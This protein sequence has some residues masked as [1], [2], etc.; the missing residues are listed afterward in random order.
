MTDVSMHLTAQ[1]EQIH[2]TFLQKIQIWIFAL[3][4][5]FFTASLVPLLLG[6]TIAYYETS[7]IDLI[8]GLLTLVAGVS[9]HAGTNLINDYYDRSTD[10]INIYYSQ[11]NGGSR[12]IQNDIIAPRKI[13]QASVLSYIVGSVTAIIIL[14][15]IQGV[16]LII[17]LSV[18]VL[19]GFFY[20]ALPVSLSYRGLGEIAV[21]VGFGPLGVFSAYYIQLGHINS[22]LLTIVSIPIAILISLVLFLNEFQDFEADATAGKNTLVVM[23]GKKKSV[24]IYSVGMILAYITL[25]LFVLLS[26][27]PV[28]T[29][30]PMITFPVAVKAV[31]HAN[32]NYDKI[33]ELLPA[34]GQTILIHFVFGLLLAVSFVIA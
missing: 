28:I 25:P 7:S 1:D 5:P 13:L 15:L 8:L 2:S 11:F 20:T 21:F 9:I 6:M 33:K 34:N 19:L 31:T 10:D 17:F 22:S 30:L 14:F 26:W 3:R 4:A 29:L 12:M 24:K 23:L 27:L 16:L 18:A 32:G